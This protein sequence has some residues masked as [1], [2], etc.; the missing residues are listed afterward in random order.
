MTGK[1]IVFFIFHTSSAPS[2]VF[3]DSSCKYSTS[4]G[5]LNLT[6]LTPTNV[7]YISHIPLNICESF[8]QN[9]LVFYKFFSSSCTFQDLQTKKVIGGGYEQDGLYYLQCGDQPKVALLLWHVMSL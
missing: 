1:S 2:I 9:S 6:F 7:N 3:T 4:T 8:D 5:I